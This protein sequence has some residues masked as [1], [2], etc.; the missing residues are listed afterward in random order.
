MQTKVN[1]VY[2]TFDE[3]T[4]INL[5]ARHTGRRVLPT[6]RT[7]MTHVSMHPNPEYEFCFLEGT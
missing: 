6:A 2:V 7:V 3:D 1:E 4:R 5:L